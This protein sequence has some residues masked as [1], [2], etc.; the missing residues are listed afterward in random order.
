MATKPF[1]KSIVTPV[2]T[3]IYPHLTTPDA[4]WGEPTYKCNLRLTG[5][6]ATQFIAKIEEMKVQAM[7]H[8]GVKDLIVPIVPA[9]DDD[10][11]EIPGA[12]DV[13]TKAK[14]FF[15]QADGSMVENNLTIVDA[16]KN[17]Y[18][19]S[20]GA[21]WGGSKLKLALTVG[22]VSSAVYQ[23]LM[24]RVQAVQVID[25][26]TG[27][28]GGANAFDKEDGFT[29]EPKAEVKVAEGEDE[30]IDF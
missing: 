27:G 14:A 15:K 3:A 30:T 9:L 11:N 10:K 29:A 25:L 12:F 18:D 28:Q 5:E 6:D 13:K 23:G 4:K 22:A 26:V 21:I 16:Q 7:E 1:R 17:P 2:G 19:A 20:N 24:L 8:L